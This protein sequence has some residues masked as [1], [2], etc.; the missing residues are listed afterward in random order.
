M[1]PFSKLYE[2]YEP[3]YR[4]ERCYQWADTSSDATR[5]K[6]MKEAFVIAPFHA[7][8]AA[9]K[10]LAW[11][12]EPVNIA[13]K[14]GY[15]KKLLHKHFGYS[16]AP[17]RG[18]DKSPN[19]AVF[20]RTP[21]WSYGGKEY[22]VD[23]IHSIGAALDSTAQP[24]YKAF[25]ANGSLDVPKLQEFYREVYTL[26]FEA[27]LIVQ[28]R[29]KRKMELQLVGLIGSS[30]FWHLPERD[31][32]SYDDLITPI[33]R[34]IMQGYAPKI[35]S[36]ILRYVHNHKPGINTFQDMQHG[37][38]TQ[39]KLDD[40][41]L[42]N[43]WD[44]WSMLGNGNEYDQSLDG[45]W[46]RASCIAFLGWPRS[47][48]HMKFHF[49][50]LAGAAKTSSPKQAWHVN[51][52]HATGTVPRAQP[53][54]DSAEIASGAEIPN[55]VFVTVENGPKGPGGMFYRVR[56]NSTHKGKK[57]TVSG[58]VRAEY[59]VLSSGAAAKKS[60]AAKKA[61]AAKRSP[62]AKKK[63]A[64]KPPAAKKKVPAAKKPPAA[65]KK[66]PAAAQQHMSGTVVHNGGGYY[67]IRVSADRHKLLKQGR[68][69]AQRASLGQFSEP[70][71]WTKYGSKSLG[72]HVTLQPNEAVR[73]LGAQ[74]A[75]TVSEPYDFVDG[76]SHWIVLPIRTMQPHIGCPYS[77]HLT[78]AQAPA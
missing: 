77:C 32:F 39:S 4:P 5:L 53:Q 67:A 45:Y 54:V 42:T 46:G 2:T 44:C 8:Q 19:I 17:Y 37:T 33:V 73:H 57:K 66:A 47:N 23:V 7:K 74:V 27:A 38:I 34:D 40:K 43:A 10:E 52:R 56:Y 75:L 13:M 30:A 55:H 21:F 59:L 60:P 24:D 58:W 64:K 49:V 63:A 3:E 65:K 29:R 14:R 70:A 62:A 72:P 25:Y 50:K 35:K 16:Q 22:Q 69:Y 28:K 71:S 41:I 12:R 36:S 20:T 51:T 68:E 31:G 15:D 11:K 48:P 18:A 9:V 78:I 1:T 61:P 26:M 6:F 76:G